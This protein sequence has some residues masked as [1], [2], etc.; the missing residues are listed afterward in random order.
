MTF[1]R[2]IIVTIAALFLAS[3]TFA[4]TE[5][6]LKERFKQRY[7]ELQELKLAGKVGEVHTGYVEAV[8]PQF[9]AEPKVKGL[10]DDENRDR[11]ELYQI[12]AKQTGTTPEAVATRN[13]ARNFDK[14]RPGEWLKGPDGI[15]R[16]K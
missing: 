16:Q 10:V 9:E 13:A 4:A 14:A 11:K 3:F 15:W 6:E 8:K 2:M 7:P 5:G 12:I 1:T